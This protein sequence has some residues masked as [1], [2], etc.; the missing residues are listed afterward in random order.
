MGTLEMSEAIVRTVGINADEALAFGNS[1]VHQ[2]TL[3]REDEPDLWKSDVVE[4]I[5]VATAGYRFD[6][7]DRHARIDRFSQKCRISTMESRDQLFATIE[8][9]E[10]NVQEI[11]CIGAPTAIGLSIVFEQSLTGVIWDATGVNLRALTPEEVVERLALTEFDFYCTVDPQTL[12]TWVPQQ[13]TSATAEQ[14]Q[15]IECF[16]YPEWVSEGWYW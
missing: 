7:D 10:M 15:G 11:P 6:D 1:S 12:A 13:L 9:S 5:F 16:N 4:E 8:L 2:L 14:L 3:G